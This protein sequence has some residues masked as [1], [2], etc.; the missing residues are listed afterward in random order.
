MINVDTFYSICV[1]RFDL[2]ADRVA[3]AASWLG[4]PNLRPSPVI[5]GGH[6][7]AA[8][9]LIWAIEGAQFGPVEL[10]VGQRAAEK[11]Q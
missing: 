3:L 5:C 8:R 2:I 4:R 7:L 11:P 6:Q 9:G 10:R 1:H